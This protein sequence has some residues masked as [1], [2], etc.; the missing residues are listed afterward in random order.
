MLKIGKILR[1]L[2]AA[3]EMET[4]DCIICPFSPSKPYPQVIF[5]K[6]TYN[7][8]RYICELTHGPAPS[9]NHHAAHSCGKS[10]CFNKHHVYWATPA[11]NIA[12]KQKH[13]TVIFGERHHKC[14]LSEFDVMEIRRLLSED[15]SYSIIA[16]QFNVSKSLIC[17]ISKGGGWK[18][19]G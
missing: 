9:S 16:K 6:R 15:I 13:G 4:D 14:K 2:Q 18:R 10:R 7:A 17:W 11:Q 5:A 3:L 12:D 1:F 19:L 8:N